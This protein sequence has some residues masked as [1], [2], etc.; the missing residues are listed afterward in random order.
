MDIL[1][2]IQNKQKEMAAKKSRQATLK[3]AAGDHRYRIL[4]GW[5]GGDDKQFWHDW[6]IHFIKSPASGDKPEAVY[7]CTEKTF[8]KPCEVCEC[9]KKSLGV[10]TDDK[11][12]EYLKKAGSAQRYLM[13]VLHLTGSEPT[14]VQVL[15]VG[16]GVFESICELVKEYGDITDL[17]SGIDIKIKREG[18]G[19]DTSYTVLPSAKST[20]V[21]K[22]ILANLVNLDEFVA[23]ENSAGQLKAL[24]A[25]GTIIGVSAPAT[26]LPASRSSAALADM[27][28]AE[29][30]DYIPVSG[31]A[32]KPADL[33]MDDLD[34]LDELLG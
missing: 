12:T 28:D 15:E 5:R 32:S 2:L 7:V 4:P 1:A 11:M 9:I 19:L 31:S 16:Q 3:P 21:N 30:A 34:E 27:S 22:A 8:G 33:D 10:S 20:P 13:N 25:I 17:D 29:D 18:S 14:K 24:N 23:Q 6:A 26:A